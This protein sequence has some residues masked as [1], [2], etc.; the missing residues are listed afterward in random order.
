MNK[1]FVFIHSKTYDKDL[2]VFRDKVVTGD[3]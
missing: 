2:S 1:P 3:S